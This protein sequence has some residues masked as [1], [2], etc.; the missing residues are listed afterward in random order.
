MFALTNV[1]PPEMQTPALASGKSKKKAQS[2][3]I[4]A[5]SAH[6]AALPKSMSDPDIHA[7]FTPKS[8]K[9]GRLR[10]T[11]SDRN[12]TLETNDMRINP[13]EISLTDAARRASASGNP[14][15]NRIKRLISCNHSL[16]I[17]VKYFVLIIRLYLS[18]DLRIF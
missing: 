11:A 6:K 13:L 9:N 3:L 10:K 14:G 7:S 12:A 16:M 4:P 1:H 5:H 17:Q 2:A 8:G 18:F 15:L